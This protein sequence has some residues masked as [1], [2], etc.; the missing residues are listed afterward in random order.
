MESV[1]NWWC[2][3]LKREQISLRLSIILVARKPRH[4]VRA[5]SVSSVLCES[6]LTLAAKLESFHLLPASALGS[7]QI[8]KWETH[9]RVKSQP[10]LF[11]DGM[12]HFIVSVSLMLEGTPH[13]LLCHMVWSR[14][15][16][17]VSIFIRFFPYRC[18]WWWW[19]LDE[20]LCLGA[21]RFLEHFVQFHPFVLLYLL[22]MDCNWL[23]N[24]ATLLEIVPIG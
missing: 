11:S 4:S 3:P 6:D 20:A 1:W 8:L 19:L 9:G 7:V 23:E 18:Q 2:Y 10:F 5:S 22:R 14:N 16:L 12:R 24:D 17:Y 15:S 13:L 21:K